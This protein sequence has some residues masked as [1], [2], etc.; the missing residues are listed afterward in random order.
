MRVLVTGAAGSIGQVVTAGL[1]ALGHEVVGLDLAPA[2]EGVDLAWHVVDCTDPDAVDEAFEAQPLD[3]VVHLAGYPDELDLPGSLASHVI[4]TAALLDA[5]LA[6]RVGRIVYA[7]SNHAVG[8]TPR[9]DLVGTDA[10]P[11][12]DTFYGVGKVAAEAVLSLYADRYG[13]DA[14][15]CRIGSFLPRP[16]TVRNLSTWLSH[17]DCVRMVEAALTT[18]A[19]G[20]GVLYGISANTDAWWDLEPGRALG[21]QPQDDAASYADDIAPRPEDEAEAAHVG[22]PFAGETFYRPALPRA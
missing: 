10:R 2:P 8:R 6:H 11:R 17:D 16:E 18:P 5:M 15:A 14:V 4:T 20:F 9:R 3:A 1:G 22:G 7:S 12:P 19:P 13:I 21:Y